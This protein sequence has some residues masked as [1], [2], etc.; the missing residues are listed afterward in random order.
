MA[1]VLFII[2]V[3]D[4]CYAGISTNMG[5]GWHAIRIVRT[6]VTITSNDFLIIEDKAVVLS[7]LS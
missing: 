3:C 2:P 7:N 5:T 4:A 6:T 1:V